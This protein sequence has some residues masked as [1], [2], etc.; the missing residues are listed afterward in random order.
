MVIGSLYIDIG[1]TSSIRPI[2]NEK[3]LCVL[4][5]SKKAWFTNEQF[6]VEGDIIEVN[7]NQSDKKGTP[8]FK[9]HGQWDSKIYVTK[10]N[11]SV[12]DESTTELGFTKSPQPDNATF[13]Y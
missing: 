5:W 3:L 13:M 10:Y 1:G 8:L 9:V 6:K 11:N 2:R 12:L 4:K 7:E